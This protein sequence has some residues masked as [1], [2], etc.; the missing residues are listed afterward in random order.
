MVLK[1]KLTIGSML[2]HGKGII[3]QIIENR[4]KEPIHVDSD[5]EPDVVWE[6]WRLCQ[7]TTK[8]RNFLRIFWIVTYKGGFYFRFFNRL[9][10]SGTKIFEGMYIPFSERT[11]RR[12][13]YRMFGWKFKLL[14]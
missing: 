9:G 8:Q 10:L 4:D 13:V 11:G 2:I 14:T 5:I 12:K 7:A 6:H 3:Q 1:H